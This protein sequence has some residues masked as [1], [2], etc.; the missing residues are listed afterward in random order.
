[1][2][3]YHVLIPE[4]DTFVCSI[5]LTKQQT[6]P[7]ALSSIFKRMPWL[8][9][10]LIAV[11][12]LWQV[13]FLQ[14]SMKHDIL[15]AYLPWLNY[16]SDSFQNGE[17][18]YWNPYQNLGNPVYSNPQ[19]SV[20]DPVTL[21]LATTVGI[22]LYTIHWL[23]VFY[24]A[25]AGIGA[26]RL[27]RFFNI[28]LTS[29]Y[30]AGICFMFSGIFISHSQ[31]ITLIA[32]AAWAPFVLERFLQLLRKPNLFYA[33]TL[34]LFTVLLVT[35]GYQM[36]VLLVFYL[37][38]AILVVKLLKLR[39][40]GQKQQ[41][42]RVVKYG[43]LSVLLTLVICTPLILSLIEVFPEMNR[44]AALPTNE[45][46][47]GG[48]PLSSFVSFLLPFASVK[49]EFY[50]ID[51][52]LSNA[53][54][55]LFLFV[56]FV[57]G[58]FFRK[59]RMEKTLLISGSI[60]LVLSLGSLLPFNQYLYKILP[61]VDHF[62]FPTFFRVITVLCFIVLAVKGMHRFFQSYELHRKKLTQCIVGTAAIVAV[63]MVI[64]LFHV[65][66]GDL[67][68]FN[69]N[70]IIDDS[71]AYE[72][73]L[74]QG[75]LQLVFLTV[76]LLA[77]Q[78]RLPIA[79]LKRLL[80]ILIVV[81]VVIATQ[82]NMHYTITS[83]GLDLTEIQAKLDRLP[84]NYPTPDLLPIAETEDDQIGIY[85]LIRNIH[86]FLR[87]P[88][89]RGL[90]SFE[91]K[92]YSQFITKKE[93]KENVLQNPLVYL[94]SDI[95]HQN[96]YDNNLQMN[97]TKTLFVESGDLS[98]IGSISLASNIEDTIIIA[99]FSP[100]RIKLKVRTKEKQ[101]LVYLQSNYPGWEVSIDG[102]K[103][104]L[105]TSNYQFLSTIVPAGEHEVIF[106]FKK[107]WVIPALWL[108]L[109]L[110]VLTAGF[111]CFLFY[112]KKLPLD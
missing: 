102:K 86:T 24:V 107:S 89:H 85:P 110:F 101:A 48:F 18:P 2:V 91:L 105:F 25:L 64:S 57:F 58:L 52:A 65:S 92:S 71:T 60:A 99:S 70:N 69:G 21:L 23:Y 77:L 14:D 63:F 49:P 7:M 54:F 5:Q 94:S 75:I 26:F 13:A 103:S 82:L 42:K 111:S 39:K 73:I 104:T 98:S 4:I 83:N 11:I 50:A 12:G 41:L 17:F 32:A 61:F 100:H 53:Y 10:G 36:I 46:Q 55:G 33:L 88:T 51:P 15:N 47:Y 66:L 35:S 76:F 90:S 16:V 22:N 67:T 56:F 19:I 78:K 93:L 1:M 31:H 9:F 40:E 37:M 68:Y 30:A 28:D 3:R 44:G 6:Y 59:D 96:R 74:V 38:I 43:A 20:W 81:D 62:R 8:L 87:K 72:H 109:I 106:E 84:D 97:S 80:L 108:E 34:V 79:K 27:A 29:A 95:Q 45:I 112:K